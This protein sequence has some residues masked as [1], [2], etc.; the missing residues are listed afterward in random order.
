MKLIKRIA[1]IL[2][3]AATLV[4]AVSV[5]AR[6]AGIPEALILEQ[7]G[8]LKGTGEGVTT[9][10][11]ESMQTRYQVAWIFLRLLGKEN[12]AK[13]WIGTQ[14]FKDAAT[15]KDSN[16]QQLNAE[17]RRMLAYLYSHK[18][19]GFR[20][21]PDDTF[22]PFKT[23]DY[24]MYYKLMLVACGYVEG[25]NFTWKNVFDKAK[26]YD[27]ISFMQSNDEKFTIDRLSEITVKTL[28]ANMRGG[29]KT[30][31]S[32]LIETDKIIDPKK[33]ADLDLY[34]H[35]Y[36]SSMDPIYNK[37]DTTNVGPPESGTYRLPEIYTGKVTIKYDMVAEDP[38]VDASVS[39]MTSPVL[40]LNH[41]DT[42]SHYYSHHSIMIAF[43]YG[44]IKAING[45]YFR[46][47]HDFKINTV[48]HIRIEANMTE[49][50]YSVYVTP[51][52]GIEETLGTNLQFRT[53][54]AP[55]DDPANPYVKNAEDIAAVVVSGVPEA[56]LYMQNLV[57]NDDT[58]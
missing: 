8:I 7:L 47:W 57:I 41:K 6:A 58:P 19:L 38:S 18:E 20:G 45:D 39:F 29:T 24:R 42:N 9:A 13:S 32:K 23:M 34:W 2:L 44:K 16:G 25:T 31:I 52:G 40:P 51:D 36:D 49:H 26:E 46:N 48:Y 53:R 4:S 5:P 43:S 56:A 21:Y 35:L 1:I 3:L 28:K 17:N 27:L 37:E 30:L 11:R 50:C 54:N 22:K 15:V 55:F 12:E 10:Y 33:A 14:N